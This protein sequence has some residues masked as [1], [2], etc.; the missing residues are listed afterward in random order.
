M[1]ELAYKSLFRK[2]GGNHI[3]TCTWETRRHNGLYRRLLWAHFG[4]LYIS[5]VPLAVP[6]V[7]FAW[8]DAVQAIHRPAVARYSLRA[9][10]AR[11]LTFSFKLELPQET[12]NRVRTDAPAANRIT[13]CY[14]CWPA[15]WY[16]ENAM[17][18]IGDQ[19]RQL[20]NGITSKKQMAREKFR[21]DDSRKWNWIISLNNVEF[22][23]I[24]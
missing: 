23:L 13:D 2:Y 22:D 12:W 6:V 1:Q 7:S 8:L 24:D 21:T 14:C 16:D 20:K 5:G 9:N 4:A 10:Q 18:F 19:N 17:F 15:F 3:V 11:S